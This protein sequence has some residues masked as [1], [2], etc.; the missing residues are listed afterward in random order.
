MST[1][2]QRMGCPRWDRDQEWAYRL[3]Y[4]HGFLGA[5]Y[6]VEPDDREKRAGTLP[7]AYDQAAALFEAQIQHW[8]EEG[9]D[10]VPPALSVVE[11]DEL[12]EV[13]VLEPE[14]AKAY[15][16]GYRDGYKAALEAYHL[17]AERR[18]TVRAA[19]L[20]LFEFHLEYLRN[21]PEEG[22]GTKPPAVY[23]A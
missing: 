2:E 22:E 13:P 1:T 19:T 11:L 17:L 12:G 14:K 4:S 23:A 20:Q 9:Q 15:R 3:G 10:N 18:A 16:Y 21:W 6:G 5:M 7:E 8:P